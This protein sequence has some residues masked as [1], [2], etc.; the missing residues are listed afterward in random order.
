[1]LLRPSSSGI[2]EKEML[3][4]PWAGLT[5]ESGTVVMNGDDDGIGGDEAW[6]ALGDGVT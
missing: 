4:E 6:V 5:V 1:L 3:V 2:G